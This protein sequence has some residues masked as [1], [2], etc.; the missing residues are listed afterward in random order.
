M[1]SVEV[2][3]KERMLEIENS[4]VVSGLVDVNGHLI[5]YQRDSTEIDAGSLAGTLPGR[6]SPDGLQVT[7]WDNALETGFY[8]GV[9]AANSPSSL[10][11]AGGTNFNGIVRIYNNAGARRI[12]QELRETRAS[13]Y[14]VLYTRYYDG[15]SWLPW[16][17]SYPNISSSL[18]SA[19]LDTVLEAGIYFQVTNTQ[20]TPAN[21]YPLPRGSSGALSSGGTAGM[22]EVFNWR[23]DQIF[24]RFTRRPDGQP[25]QVW[26]R[27]KY[28]SGAWTPW[29]EISNG[30]T[31]W[32]NLQSY[33][34]SGV[35]YVASNG[36]QARR[37]GPF[38]E[39]LISYVNVD[40]VSI[41]INGDIGNRIL[42]NA[43]PAQFRPEAALV[44]LTSAGSGVSHS[45]YINSGGQVALSALV[46]LA[47]QTG[48]QTV[49]DI[50]ISIYG[51]YPAAIE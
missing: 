13:G 3:T 22:L 15:T 26:Q 36:I 47:T 5:L 1:G 40:S 28:T 19:N 11:G 10:D 25:Q 50:P 43:I 51:F 20:G 39:L 30:S 45:S 16:V 46:P 23:A 37:V 38:V 42:L 7:D 2:F 6:L 34:A 18:G 4:T 9:G 31:P 24:Q 14:G 41:P 27:G 12:V 21:N 35:N 29:M 48:S 49:T 44:G 33:V 32:V 17:S 8:F